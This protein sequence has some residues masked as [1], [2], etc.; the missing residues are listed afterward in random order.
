MGLEDLRGVEILNTPESI[1]LPKF[2]NR[3]HGVWRS[4]ESFKGRYK[5]LKSV[6]QSIELSNRVVQLQ[7]ESAIPKWNGPGIGVAI[8]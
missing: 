4:A 8:P 7:L 5:P 1:T 3:R 6:A 2:P